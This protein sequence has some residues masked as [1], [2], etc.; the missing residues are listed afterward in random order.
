MS[1]TTSTPAAVVPAHALRRGT[2]GFAAVVLFLTGAIVS[3][4]TLFVLPASAIARLPLTFLIVLGVVFAIAHYVAMYGLIRRRDW[5]APLTLY[6]VAV[7]LGLAAF[8]GLL[9]V[10]GF[11][12]LGRPDAEATLASRVQIVGLLVWLT[13]SWIVAGRFAVRGMAAPDRTPEPTSDEAPASVGAA[14][15]RVIIA[16]AT[17]TRAGLRTHSAS[18]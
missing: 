11:D 13:G 12:P 4:V 16:D 3:A 8:G 5:A 1:A 14:H 10:T 9:L 15:A 2:R 7:G 6:V 17:R 18:A